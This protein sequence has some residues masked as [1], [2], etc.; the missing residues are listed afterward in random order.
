MRSIR[1]Y[2]VTHQNL[3]F[4]ELAMVLH[5]VSALGGALV[6]LLGASWWV[7]RG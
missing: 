1:I 5:T 3:T 6:L 2:N 7:L 4:K